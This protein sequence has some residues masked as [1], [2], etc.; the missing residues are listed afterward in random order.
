V[1][2]HFRNGWIFLTCIPKLI[3]LGGIAEIIEPLIVENV[4]IKAKKIGDKTQKKMKLENGESST[5]GSKKKKM[6]VG[7]AKGRK[8]VAKKTIKPENGNSNT[9]GGNEMS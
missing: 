2:S 6:T 5:K 1:S 3:G 4:I 9:N 7:T 8:T